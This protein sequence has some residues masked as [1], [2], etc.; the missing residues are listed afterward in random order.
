MSC[1]VL[2]GA[3][4]FRQGDGWLAAV[5]ANGGKPPATEPLKPLLVCGADNR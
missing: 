4:L 5:A 1:V 2:V 3:W